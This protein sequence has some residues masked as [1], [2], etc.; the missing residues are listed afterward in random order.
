[1]RLLD[2]V[3]NWL[4]EKIDGFF[5]R[6][7]QEEIQPIEIGKRLLRE[8]EQQKTI[9]VAKTY[10]PDQYTVS[11]S[12]QDYAKMYSLFPRLSEEMAQYLAAEADKAGYLMVTEI[13]IFWIKEEKLHLGQLEVKS[14]FSQ[15]L[16]A[17]IRQ[18]ELLVIAGNDK[19]RIFSVRNEEVQIGRREDN[20][21]CLHDLNISRLHAKIKF[22]ADG[23]VIQDSNSTNGLKVNGKKVKDHILQNKDIIELGTTA[24]LVKVV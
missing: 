7:F 24:L 10:I 16:P 3:E 22:T 19:G 1:M 20:E 4:E 13:Q 11:L 12:S 9:S 14:A 18:I 8:M 21:I 6:R 17:K 15:N 23:L 2:K 5:G